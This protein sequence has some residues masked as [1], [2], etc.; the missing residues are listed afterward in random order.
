MLNKYTKCN[1][2]GSL[3]GTTTIVDIRRQKVSQLV[4]ET[5]QLDFSKLDLYH[6]SLKIIRSSNHNEKQ[7]IQPFIFANFKTRDN[8]HKYAWVLKY[9]NSYKHQYYPYT[10]I[11]FIYPMKC[12][13]EGKTSNIFL[14]LTVYSYKGNHRFRKY[15]RR[16]FKRQLESMRF[17]ILRT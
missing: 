17:S 11:P 2:R 6:E 7:M 16:E 5:S 10:H 9:A 15:R 13:Y 1:F 4:S 3:C 14:V 8:T 12:A